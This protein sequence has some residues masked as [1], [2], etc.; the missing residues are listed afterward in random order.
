[1]LSEP[2]LLKAISRLVVPIFTA[3]Y[4]QVLII[5][6]I[7]KQGLNDLKLALLT[8]RRNFSFLDNHVQC[9]YHNICYNILAVI[10]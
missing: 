5:V 6:N 10:Y 1:M 4:P 2:D 8:F 7:T 3:Q 9:I